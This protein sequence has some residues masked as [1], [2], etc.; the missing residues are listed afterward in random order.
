MTS[1]FDTTDLEEKEK[2]LEGY[3]SYYNGHRRMLYTQKKERQRHAL[4]RMGLDFK[5]WREEVF[6]RD[7]NSCQKC[8]S[9]ERINPH[10]IF[11]FAQHIDKRFDVN[12]GITLCHKHH[13]EFHKIYGR[14]DNNLQQLNEFLGLK[15]LG[16]K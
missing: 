15:R 10:H 13:S 1:V 5:I 14:K 11:N 16:I 12:N 2:A 8:G 9:K 7:G 6:K 3:G 4:I